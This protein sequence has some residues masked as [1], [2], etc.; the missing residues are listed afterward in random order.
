MII[1][2]PNSFCNEVI[3]SSINKGIFL[4]FSA[5]AGSIP[6]KSVGQMTNSFYVIE[7]GDCSYLIIKL[8]VIKQKEII[9]YFLVN[10][11]ELKSNVS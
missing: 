9:E 7:R 1:S 4:S 11:H 6:A 2:H 3:F 5:I 8:L 10:A